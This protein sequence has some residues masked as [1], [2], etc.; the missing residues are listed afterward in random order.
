MVVDDLGGVA[1]KVVTHAPLN[2]L[3]VDLHEAVSVGPSLLVVEAQG[4]AH[5]MNDDP[6]LEKKSNYIIEMVL[7]Q[8]L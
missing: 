7:I 5:L 6:F 8:T 4:M 1:L 3:V 2:V